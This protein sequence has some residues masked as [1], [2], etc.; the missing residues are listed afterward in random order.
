MTQAKALRHVQTM[1]LLIQGRQVL[2]SGNINVTKMV[3]KAQTG[4]TMTKW[5]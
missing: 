4:K 3:F 1:F 5:H 2:K